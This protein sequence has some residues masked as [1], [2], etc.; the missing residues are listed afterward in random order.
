MSSLIPYLLIAA[1]LLAG[2]S[3]P[4]S[5]ASKEPPKRYQLHG[6]VVRLDPQGKTATINAQRIDGWMEAM[7]MEYPVKDA[8][9]FATLHPKDCIDATVLV[10]GTDFWV[11]DVKHSDAAPGGCVPPKP[12]ADEKK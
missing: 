9:D 6:E 5:E 2:C 7:S 11:A 1:A 12:S 8:Q 4:T 3:R 10:Q